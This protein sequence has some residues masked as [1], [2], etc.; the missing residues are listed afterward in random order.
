MITDDGLQNASGSGAYG[1]NGTGSTNYTSQSSSIPPLPA[2]KDL[3][4]GVKAS[5]AI[6]QTLTTLPPSQLLDILAQMKT[7]ATNEPQRATELLQQ[8]PQLAAAVFQ[9]LLLMGLVSRDAISSV[10]EQG[11]PPAAQG[12]PAPA[13]PGF[14]GVPVANNTPPVAG[15]PYQ[16]PAAQGYG[17]APAP[18]AAAPLAQDPE[19]L[20]RKVMELTDEQIGM[21]A[22]GDR[23][24]ILALRARFGGQRR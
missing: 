12:Y 5:D 7:L 1:S 17:A 2:G 20:M 24:E 10:I 9:A 18:A 23:N 15:M 21:L 13:M 22:E 14:P 11:A 6:S 8:A 19:A 3:P 16:P 4:P